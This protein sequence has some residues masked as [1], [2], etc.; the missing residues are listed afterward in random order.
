MHKVLIVDDHNM[1]CEGLSRVL[2]EIEGL[3]VLACLASGEEALAFSRR[4]PPDVILMDVHM[5]G[6]GGFGATI[7]IKRRF[8]EVQII[9]MSGYEDAPYLTKIM[10][11]GASGYVDKSAP[12]SELVDAIHSV[13]NGQQY[14]GKHLAQKIALQKITHK[15]VDVP[16]ERLADRELQVA[17]MIVNCMRNKD[18][19]DKLSIS[20]KT[21]STYRKRIFEKLGIN[22]DVELTRMAMKYNML[23]LTG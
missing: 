16:F 5:P 17:Q 2:A 10:E 14:I 11:A 8:P 22:S 20:E 12:P 13:L 1:L 18:I 3:E 4:T 21:V 9:A 7:E 19:A 23:G 6:I 15:G